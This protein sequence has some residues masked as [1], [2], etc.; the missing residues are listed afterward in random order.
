MC[1]WREILEIKR[2]IYILPFRIYAYNGYA[3]MAYAK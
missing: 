3:F 2:K 1:Q